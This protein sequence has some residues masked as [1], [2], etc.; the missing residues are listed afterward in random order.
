MRAN[1]LVKHS[2]KLASFIKSKKERGEL[3][4]FF[5]YFGFFGVMLLRI[6]I[7]LGLL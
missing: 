7:L 4:M 1:F 2:A 3:V 6:S 5:T